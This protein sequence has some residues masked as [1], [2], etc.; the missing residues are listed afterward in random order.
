ML[1][2]LKIN[3]FQLVLA[4][5]VAVLNREDGL[6]YTDRKL[7]TWILQR[8]SWSVTL[9]PG[10]TLIS[11]KVTKNFHTDSLHLSRIFSDGLGTREVRLTTSSVLVWIW[12][13]CFT[14]CGLGYL[15]PRAKAGLRS[16]GWE[17]GLATNLIISLSWP[18]SCFYGHFILGHWSVTCGR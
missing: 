2:V 9:F 12:D 17:L 1:P 10:L 8:V 6:L 11:L 7:W 5:L 14:G 15:P 16:G 13:Q 18:G 3:Y 4:E